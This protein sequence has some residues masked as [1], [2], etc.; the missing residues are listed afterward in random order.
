MK[1][2]G[3][4]SDGSCKFSKSI[5]TRVTTPSHPFEPTA[6]KSQKRNP[7]EVLK[8]MQRSFE[9][10]LPAMNGSTTATPG[11]LDA[12]LPFVVSV[13]TTN[14]HLHSNRLFR[15]IQPTSPFRQP[16]AR[17]SPN[18]ALDSM[19]KPEGIT[20]IT[21]SLSKATLGDGA[22]AKDLS[23][24]NTLRPR[25]LVTSLT[26]AFEVVWYKPHRSIWLQYAVKDQA[27]LA[28]RTLD[29]KH[30]GGVRVRCKLKE[31]RQRTFSVQLQGVPDQ[32]QRPDIEALLPPDAVPFIPNFSPLSY[33]ASLDALTHIRDKIRARTGESIKNCKPIDT[34]NGSKMKAEIT[35]D[36]EALNL[37]EHAKALD[38]V[39][40]PELGNTK[41][42]FTE[43]L[44]LYVAI[45]SSLYE[46][47]T[48][49]LKGICNRAWSEHHITVKIFDGD[50][51]YRQSTYLISIEGTGRAAV[52]IVKAEI[53][54]CI[55][56]DTTHGLQLQAGQV[57][58]RHVI[59]LNLTKQYKQATEGGIERLQKYCGE[60]AVVFDDNPDLPCI[61][62]ETTDDKFDKAKSILFQEKPAKGD[63]TGECSICAEVDVVLL[64]TPGCGHTCCVECL[65]TYCT[66]DVAAQLPL[67]CFSAADCSTFLPIHWLE[68]HLS[69]AAYQSLFVDVIAAQCKENPDRFVQ[70]AGLD[71][72]THL[73]VNPKASSKVICP[74]CLTVN[75]T[76]C[77]GQYH[78]NETCEAS[79]AR[80][81]PQD[82]TLRRYL[83]ASGGKLCPQCAT[84]T[85]KWIGCAHVECLVCRVHYCWE[86]LEI[87]PDMG[88]VY[89]HMDAVHGGIDGQGPI[90]GEDE[91]EGEELEDGVRE[92]L[93]AAMM[94]EVPRVGQLEEGNVRA[95]AQ[96]AIRAFLDVNGGGEAWR[97][98]MQARLDDVVRDA[99]ELRRRRAQGE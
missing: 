23:L 76:S 48:K 12:R 19:A 45:D 46:R 91:D 42:F 50:L 71:C 98:R 33:P 93:E 77:K 32:V 15:K 72:S 21:N 99:A 78:F 97:A 13:H 36:A 3:T 62:I 10:H 16:P 43:R 20:G 4:S 61:T 74:T 94:R 2:A 90:P 86:C 70:C 11:S 49:N 60:G 22:T 65:N 52:M 26:T 51:R 28:Y 92:E 95:G 24:P 41:V 54:K 80:R 57:P 67:R 66:T 83:A 18:V 55:F 31:N 6:C 38:G 44:H 88:A 82:D 25:A 29:G 14:S 34:E 85:V 84:P 73:A 35:L 87:Y 37:S 75:C 7:M 59:Q 79:Q 9:S 58:R 89:A 8:D 63:D 81:D 47:R 39:I 17:T 5:I 27:E 64:K 69:P 56:A 30:I 53:D 96:L 40:L 68:E 1:R